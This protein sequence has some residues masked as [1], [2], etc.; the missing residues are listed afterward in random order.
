V[1]A[2]FELPVPAY[3]SVGLNQ[4]TEEA[5]CSCL[6]PATY[7]CAHAREKS[8]L[9]I[10][11]LACT[12]KTR[13]LKGGRE[14]SCRRTGERFPLTRARGTTGLPSR[15]RVLAS[16]SA[17]RHIPERMAG[18]P[19]KRQRKLGVRADDG[20]VIPFPYMPRTADLPRGWRH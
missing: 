19:L 20:S 6:P 7:M 16:S 10:L 9:P 14:C 2:D 17:A 8:R 15:L 18:S 1:K 3:K 13:P 4:T 12:G 5:R 11:L